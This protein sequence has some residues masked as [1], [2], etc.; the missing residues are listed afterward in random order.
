[1]QQPSRC[2][3]RAQFLTGQGFA[4]IGHVAEKVRASP[5][6]QAVAG[7]R[8]SS[9]GNMGGILAAYTSCLTYTT[10]D[11]S[12]LGFHLEV[13]TLILLNI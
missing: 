2:P 9:A 12:A 11:T 10:G 7:G 1:M 4:F 3:S 6:S 8:L 5:D 13:S